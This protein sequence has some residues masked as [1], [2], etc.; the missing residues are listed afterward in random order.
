MKRIGLTGGIASGKST[1]A[2]WIAARGVPVLD[3]D[4]L[5][6]ALT[7]PGMAALDKIAERWPQVVRRDGAL[8]RAA[9]GRIAFCDALQ[10]AHLEAILIPEILRAF[11]AWACALARLGQPV[12]VFDAALLFEQGLE[13][14]FD[15]ILLIAAPETLQLERL[16]ARDGL[17]IAEAKARLAAQLPLDLKRARARWILDNAGSIGELQARFEA[18]WP[19]L[20][21]HRQ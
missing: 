10:R 15:D 6:R 4:Q 11:E 8:D 3:A 13:P 7:R 20:V 2:R 1:V 18:L 5:S 12:C 17:S 19:A 9:L 16:M 21:S 14:Q